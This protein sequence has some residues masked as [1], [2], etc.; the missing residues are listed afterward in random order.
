[1][2]VGSAGRERRWKTRAL[3]VAPGS[4]LQVLVGSPG[5]LGAG[6]WPGGGNPGGGDDSGGGGGYSGVFV[7]NL[8]TLQPQVIAAGGGGAGGSVYFISSGW[9]AGAGGAGD[10]GSGGGTGSAAFTGGG[11]HG[12]TGPY[13]G[14]GGTGYWGG[15]N[16]TPGLFFEGDPTLSGGVGG[17]GQMAGGHSVESGGGGGGGYAGG[18]GGGGSGFAAMGGGFGGGGGS[19]Y[20]VNPGATTEQ[21]ASVPANIVIGFP[22]NPQTVSF[23]NGSGGA[24]AVD[25]VTLP[26]ATYVAAATGSGG[27]TVTY[28]L[29]PTSSHCSVDPNTGAVSFTGAGTCVIDAGAAAN[30]LYAAST[31][32]ATLTITVSP[33][34]VSLTSAKPAR[35]QGSTN[36]TVTLTGSGFQSGAVV[37]FSG[38]GIS[39]VSTTVTNSTTIAVKVNV[40]SNAPTGV[41]D[42][43]VTNP[44]TGATT[45]SGCFTVNAGPTVTKVTPSAVARGSTNVV[46]TVTGA[47]FKAAVKAVISGTGITVVSVVR[48]SRSKL[49][50]TITVAATATTG[51]RALT[52]TNTDG[53]K[54]KLANA[55]TIT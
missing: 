8:F 31:A 34:A 17:P 15:T 22:L 5:T 44:D 49:T 12:A 24:A 38:T 52:V 26:D 35:G 40:A 10:T 4:L 51:A 18:G 3:S 25:S 1:M 7:T 46:L 11:G 16:G 55:L 20:S 30:G 29:D 48:V 50:V 39:I 23:S 33:A 2:R 43:T 6:G 42:V 9:A 28:S 45:C 14:A 37:G 21:Q 19:S 32:N 53:G 36:Q 41:R 27:G 13:P 54:T 47:N